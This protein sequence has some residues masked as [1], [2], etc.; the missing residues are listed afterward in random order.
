MNPKR[1]WKRI[2]QGHVHN[3]DFADF[4]RLIEAFGFYLHRQESTHRMYARDAVTELVN[5]QPMKDGSAK[6]YQVRRFRDLVEEYDLELKGAA[7]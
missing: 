3:I 5:V 2:Q 4:C 6:H 1:L 7:R